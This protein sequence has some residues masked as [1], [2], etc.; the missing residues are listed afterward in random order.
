M[1]RL[2]I[3]IA[4]KVLWATGDLRLWV[5]MDLHVKDNKGGWHTQAFR[6]DP[7]SD[8][9][10]FPAYLASQLDLPMPMKAA[11]GVVHAQT[12]LEI[13][14]GFLRFR[15]AGMDATEYAVS[16]FFLGDPQSLPSGPAA[17][18]PRMLLPPLALLDQLRFRSTRTRPWRR[19]TAR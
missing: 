13:R 16:C 6:V 9:T 15:I 17:S 11:T 3:P 2:A 5:A 1:S 19:R 10:T 8:I 12:G 7:A 18:L 14:S 4:G